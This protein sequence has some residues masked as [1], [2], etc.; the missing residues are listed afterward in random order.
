MTTSKS[1]K[2]TPLAV[3]V[4]N[5]LHNLFTEKALS[6]GMVRDDGKV[7]TTQAFHAALRM[8][9]GVSDER[10]QPVN[11]DVIQKFQTQ[12]LEL[13]TRVDNVLQTEIPAMENR[14]VEKFA[15]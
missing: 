8:W 13:S 10:S 4:P 12:L 14:I 7:N 2:S 11:T 15:A 1:D 3:R 9:L 5:D 6:L